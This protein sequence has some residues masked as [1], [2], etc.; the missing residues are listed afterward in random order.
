[1]AVGTMRVRPSHAFG[2]KARR[3]RAMDAPPAAHR[4]SSLNAGSMRPSLRAAVE[5]NSHSGPPFG[6]G[7]SSKRAGP[8]C[9]NAAACAA[10]PI[11]YQR[12]PSQSAPPFSDYL[13][14]LSEH[15]DNELHTASEPPVTASK[16]S[17]VPSS[18]SPI[19]GP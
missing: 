14:R 6:S 11:T 17:T 8:S 12:E 13:T 2:L 1:M 16:G 18:E 3:C 4:S 5:D 10:D 7:S 9:Q 15:D 19:N